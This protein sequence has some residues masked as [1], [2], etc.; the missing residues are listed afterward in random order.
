MARRG[1]RFGT[2]LGAQKRKKMQ[3]SNGTPSTVRGAFQPAYDEIAR[4]QAVARSFESCDDESTYFP[5]SESPSTTP[6][7]IPGQKFAL[8]TLGTN[9]LAPRPLHK[10]RPCAR[11]YGMFDSKRD[12]R[13]HA[14]DVLSKDPKCSLLI[15]DRN[16]WVLLPETEMMRDDVFAAS[17]RAQEKVEAFLSNLSSEKSTFSE[18]IHKQ[19]ERPAAR[20]KAPLT[21]NEVQEQEAEMEVYGKPS[22]LRA[23][24]EVRG[25]QVAVV[26]VIPDRDG[27]GEALLRIYA[28]FETRNE[29]D[30]WVR[31]VASKHV[32]DYD[33]LVVSTCEWFYPN[34]TQT[35]AGA[36]PNYRI[37]ELQRIMD[38]AARN[39]VAVQE[40]KDW[41]RCQEAR[42]AEA[43]EAEKR[44]IALLAEQVVERAV[45]AALQEDAKQGV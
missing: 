16:Q 27:G 2:A 3:T 12:A 44:E 5:P 33:L 30:V 8:I 45:N 19:F 28:C 29:A 37:P 41:K 10:D 34:A 13:D 25:Q 6:F 4:R 26:S 38:A 35:R 11:I 9:V 20:G 42:E 21:E 17:Q 39:P 24:A 1:A 32:V 14:E 22:R 31:D 7:A 40:Y 23:G 15:V 43:E 18:V 36:N